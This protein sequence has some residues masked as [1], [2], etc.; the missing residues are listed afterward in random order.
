MDVSAQT[1]EDNPNLIR[2]TYQD[3]TLNG[4]EDDNLLSG[5]AGDD[6][7][8]GGA[9][10]DTYIGG[11]GNDRYI[12]ADSGDVDILNFKS[13]THE[14]DVLDISQLLPSGVT[15]SN[16]SN[17]LKVTT[18]GVYLD[19]DGAGDFS[20]DNQIAEFTEDSIFTKD[21]IQ[22]QI[23]DNTEVSFAVSTPVGVQLADSESYE[24]N[25]TLMSL[26]RRR[27]EDGT[28]TEEGV[29]GIAGFF[30]SAAGRSLIL[31]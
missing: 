2:G 20:D 13:T 26:F 15:E 5:R 18:E 22:I 6:V 31:T 1:D 30:R 10:R 14:K 4:T 24:S 9:G 11:A 29:D 19:V 8:D 16:L 25:D 12:L 28:E 21:L 23:A 27:N 3:N 7:L 17:Y